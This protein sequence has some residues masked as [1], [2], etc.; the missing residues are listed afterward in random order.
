MAAR[1]RRAGSAP[2]RPAQSGLEG[3]DG[4]RLTDPLAVVASLLAALARRDDRGQ[5][6]AEYVLVAAFFAAVA[7][8]GL[9]FLDQSVD[10][11]Q[12]ALLSVVN[13]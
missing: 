8:A 13:G 10:A 11:F 2:D 3:K 1:W 12:R 7:I 6:L 5:G 4:V 9:M